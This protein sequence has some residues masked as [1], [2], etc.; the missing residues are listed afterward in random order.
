[1]LSNTTQCSVRVGIDNPA[2]NKRQAT[3]CTV[4]W[5]WFFIDIDRLASNAAFKAVK[6]VNSALKSNMTNFRIGLA[7]FNV[8]RSAPSLGYEFM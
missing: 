8:I 4:Q 6:S 7:D 5:T 2:R 1:L 3:A